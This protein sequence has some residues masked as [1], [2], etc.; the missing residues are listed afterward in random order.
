MNILLW[1]MQSALAFLYLSGGAYKF[2][3]P[4]DVA[5]QVPMIS[6]AALRAFGVIE[7]I[8]ALLLIVPAATKWMPVLTPVAAGVLAI[9]TL[10]LAA[11]YAQVSLKIAATNPLVWAA[12]MGLLVAFVAYG[13]YAISPAV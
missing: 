12:V 2:F 11:L 9:E 4:E 3:K 5:S 6:H 1:I 10:V 13:R 7:V 8:G